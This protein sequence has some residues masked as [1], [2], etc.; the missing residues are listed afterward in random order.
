MERLSLVKYLNRSDGDGKVISDKKEREGSS[1]VKRQW[2]GH[3][4]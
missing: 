2:K 4:W 1:L 3:Y